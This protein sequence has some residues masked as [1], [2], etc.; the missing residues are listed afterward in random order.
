[1]DTILFEQ[2][3]RKCASHWQVTCRTDDGA[4]S[5]IGSYQLHGPEVSMPILTHA[6]EIGSCS[7][8][9]LRSH[10]P[11][12]PVSESQWG[13]SYSPIPGFIF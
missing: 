9:A 10:L 5:H 8:H 7:K 6:L 4:P 11:P 1:M 2:L 3:Y 12:N 13:G